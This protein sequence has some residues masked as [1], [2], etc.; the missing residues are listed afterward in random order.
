M[1]LG[2]EEKSRENNRNER[3]N[4]QGGLRKERKAKN[5]VERLGILEKG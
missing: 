5:M 3:G 1:T 2:R 4:E